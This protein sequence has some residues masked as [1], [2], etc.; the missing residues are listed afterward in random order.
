MVFSPVA[1][2]IVD[3]HPIARA[4]VRMM[5]ETADDIDVVAEAS[6]SDQALL[7]IAARNIHVVIL[8]ISLPG[9]GGIDLLCRLRRTRPEIAVLMLSSHPEETYAIRT[10]M[11]GAA[12]YLTKDVSIE[13]LVCAVRKAASGVRHFSA[14]LNERLVM[15]LQGD[16]LSCNERLSRREFDVMIRIASGETVTSIG[17]A[18]FLNRKTI[19]TYRR[20]IFDKLNIKNNADLTRYAIEEGLIRTPRPMD[21]FAPF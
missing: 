13:N 11:S 10:I 8:D 21:R 1:V 17:L 15:Q 18:M 6:T 9:E 20:R 12:G 19:S 14:W 7:Q 2:V 5:L 4:G 16:S 3:D